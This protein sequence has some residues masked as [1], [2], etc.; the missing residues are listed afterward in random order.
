MD[1]YL[2]SIQY[3]EKVAAE[4]ALPEDANSWPQEVLQELYKQVPYVADFEPHIVMDKVDAE[5]GFGLGH[6]EIQNKTELQQSATPEQK[7]A[8]GVKATRIPIII[9]N[10]KLQPFDVLVT[11]QAKMLPLTESRLRQALFRPNAFDITSRSPGDQSM[12]GQLYPPYRQN[13]G[14]GGGGTV[15]NVGMGK[16][17]SALEAFLTY[18]KAEAEKCSKCEKEPCACTKEKTS[19]IRQMRGSILTAIL[20]TINESDYLKFANKLMEP[21]LQE[22]FVKNGSATAPALQLLL[23]HTPSST[24]LA[25]AAIPQLTR[26]S[27]VQ[28]VKEAEGYVIKTAS[29][30]L[31][32]VFSQN[33]DRGE[34]VKRFGEKIALAADT[35][36]AVTGVEGSVDPEVAAPEAPPAQAIHEFGLYKVETDEGK[37]LIGFVIPNLIDIDGTAL[38]ISLFTNG[39]QTAV[40]QDIVGARSGDGGD[41]PEG[42]IGGTGCFYHLTPEGHVEAT[43][44]LEIQA[45]LTMEGDAKHMAETFDGRPIQVAQQPNIQ[46]V[47]EVDGTMLVPQD[48]RWLPMGEAQSVS[49][50][51]SEEEAGK[52]AQ[53]HNAMASVWLRSGGADSYSIDGHFVEK[54]AEEEKHFIN[55]DE[56]MFLLGGLGCTPEYSASKL[57]E[58]F[59]ANAPVAVRVF[60]SIKTAGQ[61]IESSKLA[62]AKKLASL[63]NLRKD[64]VKEAAFVPDPMAVD[65]VLS[66]GFINPENIITFISH[67]PQLDESQSRLCELLVA[68]RLGLR[69]LP[70]GALEKAIRSTEEVIDGLKTL[71]FQKS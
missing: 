17:S 1:L 32:H 22:A 71:A 41:L 40:Q 35:E 4:V 11:D 70:V 37:Q 30:N 54:I 21:S 5:R 55:R 13:N 7:A 58:A 57:A 24:K 45:G 38:P 8:V 39:S 26:P 12:I 62:A 29:H 2:E 53:A 46:Q 28:I 14:F 10:G 19:G 15:M 66:L 44:P 36:G 60:R 3:Q 48:W 67:L 33:V 51:Q 34:V 42:P 23:T 64:L 16:E 27:V 52:T 61:A 56:V 47:T 25:S 59:S 6:A 65:T 20:P 50:V 63:P 49:L 43:I 18:K 9:N 69:E 31:W 68:A